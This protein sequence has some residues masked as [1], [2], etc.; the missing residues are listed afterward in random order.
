VN[1]AERKDWLRQRQK[2]IGS[3]DAASI[4]GIGYQS[5]LD[6]YNSKI[7]PDPVN[8]IE[9]FLQRGIDLE[10]IVA[11]KYAEE[12]GTELRPAGFVTSKE[13]PWQISNPDFIGLDER[14]TEIKTVLFWNDEWGEPFTSYVPEKYWTQG[15]HQ[16]GV[17]GGCDHMDIAAFEL[18][19]WKLRIYRINFD[20]DFFEWLTSIEKRFWGMVEARRPPG[21]QWEDQF[22][23]EYLRRIVQRD[24]AV[25]LGEEWR[26]PLDELQRLKDIAKEAEAAIEPL[27]LSIQQAMGTVEVAR[28]GDWKIRRSVNKNNVLSLRFTKKEEK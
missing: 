13:N 11:K 1:E 24:K 4:I 25:L 21:P 15:Q 20:P 18:T 6:V 17:R 16:M 28:C 9:G 7:D 22:K 3:S 5:A 14:Y 2:G 26:E 23:D 8:R 12:M 10:P 19:N 27:K